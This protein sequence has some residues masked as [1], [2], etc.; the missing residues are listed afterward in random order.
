MWLITTIGFFS[1]V[2]KS[3]EEELTV[4]GRVRE[5]LERLREK[6]LPGLGDIREG[7]GTDYR[8]RAT[9]SHESVAAAVEKLTRDIDYPNF[10]DEVNRRQGATRAGV[11]GAVWQKLFRLQREV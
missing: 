3:G 8:F 5:D 6:Y 4:R 2:Q 10:K 11:Y 1:I 7:V 9:A